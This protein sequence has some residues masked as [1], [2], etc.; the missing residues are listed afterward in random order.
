MTVAMKRFLKETE[1]SIHDQI[2]SLDSAFRLRGI[3][4]KN[5]STAV[6][7]QLDTPIGIDV[8]DRMPHNAFKYFITSTVPADIVNQHK[9]V[10]QYTIVLNSMEF[11]Q[12][13]DILSLMIGQNLQPDLSSFRKKLVKNYLEIPR[14]LIGIKLSGG[15]IKSMTLAKYLQTVTGLPVENEMLNHYTVKDLGSES[16]MPLA[17]FEKYLKF[18]I[19]SD[20][21]IK[22]A[23]QI[24]QQFISNGK[25]YYYITQKNFDANPE[26]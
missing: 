1:I 4:N 25:T 7:M 22:T 8:A 3:A 26:K 20:E 5:L 18:L 12:L 24:S 11:K 14:K 10:L 17:Q 6:K 13:S 23:A 9:D 16:S 2:T 15:A 19:S 21:H